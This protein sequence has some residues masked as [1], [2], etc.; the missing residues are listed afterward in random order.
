MKRAG[1]ALI[2]VILVLTVLV[3]LATNV[4]RSTIFAQNIAIER[5]RHECNYQLT[6]GLMNY[7]IELCKENFDTL[8]EKAQKKPYELQVSNWPDG[9]TLCTG[10]VIIENKNGALN[11][12]ATKKSTK[13]ALALACRMHKKQDLFFV[14]NFRV[15]Y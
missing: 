4:L 15:V 6:H 3:I 5:Q 8:L 14:D 2:T 11:I 13:K 1:S 7:A 12:I 9:A 10:N